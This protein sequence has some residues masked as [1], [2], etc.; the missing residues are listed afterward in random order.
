ML[1]TKEAHF[2]GNAENRPIPRAGPSFRL[3]GVGVRRA[4]QERC[5]AAWVCS[6]P[7]RRRRNRSGGAVLLLTVLGHGVAEWPAVLR[8]SAFLI[9]PDAVLGSSSTTT[10]RLG[11]LY[12]ASRPARWRCTSPSSMGVAGAD[13]G[14]GVRHF[15]HLSSGAATTATPW[16]AST[17]RQMRSISAG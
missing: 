14:I 17:S 2:C 7:Y 9:F 10:K 12:R 11:I 3:R 15:A 1:L 6:D 8:T 13:L 16:T 5:R 4:S